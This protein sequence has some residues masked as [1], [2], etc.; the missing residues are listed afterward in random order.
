MS[1]VKKTVRQFIDE[2]GADKIIEEIEAG[3]RSHNNGIRPHYSDLVMDSGNQQHEFVNYVQ[4]GGGVLGIALIGYTYALEKL[5]FRFMRLAGTSAGSITTI[6]LAAVDRKN[7]PAH[8]FKLQSEIMLHELLNYDLWQLVDGH[9]LARRLIRTF[10]NYRFGTRLLKCLVVCSIVVPVLYALYMLIFQLA[11]IRINPAGAGVVAHRL[12]SYLAVISLLAL[13]LQLTLFGYFRLRFKKAGFGINPGK[14]FHRWITEV[15]EKNGVHTMNDLDKVMEDRYRDIRFRTER[16]AMNIAGDELTIPQPYLTLVASDI[17][18]Q[19]KVEFPLMAAEYWAESAKVNPA[20]FVRASMSI[21]LFFEPFRVSVPE[22]VQKHSMLQKRKN[23][24]QKTGENNRISLFVDGGILSNFP[25]NVFHNPGVP[26]ARLPTFGVKLE[27]EAHVPEG[28][29]RPGSTNLLRYLNDVFST[30]RFYYDRDF[31][32]RNAVY[33]QCIGYIDASDYNW[34]NFG[35]DEKE[36][37]EL[38]IKGVEAA[39]TFFLGGEVWV[40][41]KQKVAAAFNWEKFKHDRNTI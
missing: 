37:K 9:W 12:F 28:K 23:V 14:N 16:M 4:E 13:A 24:I 39:R 8:D 6:M 17:T 7:Y 21:P 33:E 34:L 5:G 35:M 30:V 26:V 40:D 27:D 32:K 15:L 25:I 41:G 22:F 3:I 2:T 31:L 20:D 19:T 29:S 10:I 36:K 18:A 38:F 1:V 11:Q